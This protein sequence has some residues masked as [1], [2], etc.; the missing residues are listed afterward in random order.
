M[1]LEQIVVLALIQGIT[2]FLPISSSGHL[3]LVPTLTGWPDQGILADVMVHMGSFLAVVVYFWRDCVSLL[4][5]TIDL[6]RGR[7]NPWGKLAMLILLGTIPAV[8]LGV[9][10]DITGFMDTV[11][12]MPQIVAWNA[13]IFGTLLYLCDRYG[14]S[15]RRMS[16]M[17]LS[18]A[19]IIGVAQAIAII[20]G[21][22]R[23]GITMTAAR[24]L[25][26]ER[27]EAARFAFLLGIPAIAGAGVLKLGDAVSS[28]ETIS[29]DVLLTAVLTFF[30]AL[31]TI[32][33]LMKLVRHVSFLPFAIY[34]ILL[35]AVLLGLIYSGIPFGPVN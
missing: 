34:R 12:H 13:I 32:T 17:T 33:V 15:I 10:L 14:H 9:I 16:D 8:V 26:F 1:S 6:L 19:L 7:A 18:P 31:G 3:I 22:S 11:R 23:S 35:G 27:P 5:G 2:E 20:P 24:A 4:M 30:V 21:T 25:G 28:G 29:L